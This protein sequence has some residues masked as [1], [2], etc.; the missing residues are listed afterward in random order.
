MKLTFQELNSGWRIILTVFLSLFEFPIEVRSHNIT[1]DMYILYDVH[2]RMEGKER[3]RERKRVDEDDRW[4]KGWRTRELDRERV[5]REEAAAA[6]E[7]NAPDE[8]VA[9]ADDL[10]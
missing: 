2:S 4:R 1:S 6:E 9:R 3:E 5:D 10:M 8:S 7:C